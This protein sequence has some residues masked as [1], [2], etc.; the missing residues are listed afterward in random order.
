MEKFGLLQDYLHQQGLATDTNTFRPGAARL[1]VLQLAHCH[2][3][4]QRF[5]HNRQNPAEIR[6]MGL[7]WSEGLVRRT[8]ISPN[9]TLLTAKLALK[10]GIACHLAGGTHHAHRDFA[11]GFCILNDLALTALTLLAQEKVRRVLIFDCDVHQGDGTANILMD[12]PRAFT[13]SVHCEKNFP[14][15][16]ARS[17]MDVEIA[18]GAGDDEYL[19]SVEEAFARAVDAS[20]PDLVLYDAG[21]DIYEH[22]PLGLLNISLAG[23]RQRDRIILQM[24]KKLGLPVATVIGGGYDDDRHALARRHAIVTEEAFAIW[25][26]I[27]AP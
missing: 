3:Y 14:A 19:T 21:V 7:P 2:D 1:D 26:P 24:C 12:E 17:N 22:D 4:L 10:S 15:R 13:C 25:C 18:K 16:K 11:S 8:L 5:I 27:S 23:I 9:G 6:R 20:Q